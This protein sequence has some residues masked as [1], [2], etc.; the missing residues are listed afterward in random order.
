MKLA[1]RTHQLRWILP[2]QLI[3]VI[4]GSL[5]GQV[6]LLIPSFT[7]M[8]TVPVTVVLALVAVVVLAFP[9]NAS[10]PSSRTT[11]V[12]SD[13]FVTIRVLLVILA[14]IGVTCVL[15]ALISP[16]SPSFQYFGIFAWLLALQ[17]GTATFASGSYQAM[18]PVTYVLLCA[19]LGRLNSSVQPW[20]WPLANMPGSTASYIGASALAVAL[21]AFTFL[22]LHRSSD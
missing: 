4:V 9:L 19:L 6:Q 11:S 1:M 17:L 3:A 21:V 20:A 7:G 8:G 10:W 5:Y 18:A 14:T 12:R 2:F 16:E 13:A 22:G 15:I